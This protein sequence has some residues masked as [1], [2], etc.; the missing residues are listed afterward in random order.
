MKSLLLA[1]NDSL[2]FYTNKFHS[3]LFQ[4]L[5]PPFA[6]RVMFWSFARFDKAPQH[7]VVSK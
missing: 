7:H 2:E 3:V 1:P 6:S 4:S 5:R